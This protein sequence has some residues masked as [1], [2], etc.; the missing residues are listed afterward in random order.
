MRFTNTKTFLC[1]LG[2]SHWGDRVEVTGFESHDLQRSVQ[3]FGTSWF[4]S[5]LFN[6]R[7]NNPLPYDG[8]SHGFQF[9]DTWVR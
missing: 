3:L 8:P 2:I 7:S 5:A 6:P 1:E 4:D 9:Y